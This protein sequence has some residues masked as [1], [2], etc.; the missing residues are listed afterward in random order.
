MTQLHKRF[1]DE[2]VRFLLQA[3]CKGKLDRAAV[4]ATLEI[5]KTRFF[6]LLK[7]Y[8]QDPTRLSLT[9]ERA[10]P[11]RLASTTEEAIREELVA[12]K[13]LIDDPTLPIATYNYSAIRDR[14][15]ERQIQVSLSTIIDRAKSSGCY[16]PHPKKKAH[17]RQV[18]TTSVGALVQHD[19]SY[20]RWSPFAQEEWALIH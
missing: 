16:L 5:G 19:A 3:Y 8:R 9:Y 20:H 4:E 7:E 15:E 10:T 12:E 14:L 2:Q 11:R 1:S 18:I 13:G 17:E 6:A